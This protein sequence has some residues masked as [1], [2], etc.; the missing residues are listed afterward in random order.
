MVIGRM[1]TLCYGRG[2]IY[3]PREVPLLSCS[4]GPSSLRPPDKHEPSAL[5]TAYLRL[6]QALLCLACLLTCAISIPRCPS[7]AKWVTTGR[8][9]GF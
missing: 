3:G 5:I 7:G 4:N 9:P 6:E 8:K 2:S 1:E